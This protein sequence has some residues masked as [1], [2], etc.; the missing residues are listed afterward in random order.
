MK[1]KYLKD[2]ILYYWGE[3]YDSKFFISL[4]I[5]LLISSLLFIL[6]SYL[7]Y[8]NRVN[9]ISENNKTIQEI[10]KDIEDLNKIEK[11]KEKSVVKTY[12]AS[13]FGNN[14]AEYQNRLLEI[15]DV[16]SVDYKELVNDN[17][18]SKILRDKTFFKKVWFSSKD[19]Q[20]DSKWIFQSNF[21]TDK[22]EFTSVWTLGSKNDVYACVFADYNGETN[23]F[24]NPKFIITKEGSL[25]FNEEFNSSINERLGL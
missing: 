4:P 12:Q 11:D 1:L 20:I 8:N 15:T 23:T 18:I 14:I 25:F 6:S 5:I 17:A 9:T 22:N 3:F 10:N 19:Q 16:D 7:S 24:S 2:D 21:V 13:S